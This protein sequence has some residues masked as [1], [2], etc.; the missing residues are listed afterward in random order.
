MTRYDVVVAGFGLAG[1]VAAVEC[2]RRGARTLVLDSAPDGMAGGNSLVSGGGVLSTSS[3]LGLA[4]YISSLRASFSQPREWA[5]DA[6][7]VP[8]VLRDYG[9]EV[10]LS[11]SGGDIREAPGSEAVQRWRA[12]P[13]AREPVVRT[14]QG[15]A[16][17]MGV[18]VRFESRVIGL[19][20][21]GRTQLDVGYRM[22][23]VARNA[24]A[25]HAVVLAT[26]GHAVAR[27][28]PYGATLGTPF[29]RGDALSLVGHLGAS[30]ER[31]WAYSGPYYAFRIPGTRSAITP[32]PLYGLTKD[33]TEDEAVRVVERLRGVPVKLADPSLHGVERRPGGGFR[34]ARLP[35][36]LLLVPESRLDAPLFTSWPDGHAQGWARRFGG[37]L[38]VSNETALKRSWM[39]PLSRDRRRSLG[40]TRSGDL[41]AVPIEASLLNSLGGVRCDDAGRVLG[42]HGPVAGLYAVGE[43]A[44]QFKTLYQGSANL[45]ECIIGGRRVADAAL[46]GGST[47]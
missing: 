5:E 6:A 47:E 2:A 43:A 39:R 45:T 17:D 31:P 9:V 30:T 13:D 7:R 23:G 22:D 15:L 41:F 42:V 19:S 18:E 29:A 32:H 28:S 38:R 34:R 35:S 16:L 40:C 20:R 27:W 24:F 14:V 25:R 26:G 11:R 33:T 12:R 8:S 1:A 21:S 44:S 36:A 4:R 3:P 37:G 46:G 10:C